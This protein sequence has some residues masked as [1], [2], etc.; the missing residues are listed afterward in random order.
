MVEREKQRDRLFIVTAGL[1]TGILGGSY[2]NIWPQVVQANTAR[3]LTPWSAFN[4]LVMVCVTEPGL[5]TVCVQ[6]DFQ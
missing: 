6:A 3:S 4:P 1:H 5:V 2:I